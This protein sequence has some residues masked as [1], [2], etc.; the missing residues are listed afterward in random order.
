MPTPNETQEQVHS[1]M[2][3]VGGKSF[4][5]TC[6]CNCFHHPKNK[7]EVYEC[8]ACGTWYVEDTDDT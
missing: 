2:L 4:R 7:T 5:C 3:R 1:I 8:N 6:G